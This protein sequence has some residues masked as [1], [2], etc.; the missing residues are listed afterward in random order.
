MPLEIR[1][2]VASDLNNLKQVIDSA[3]LF[4]SELLD[5]MIKPYF[6]GH[7]DCLWLTADVDEPSFVAYCAPE[8]MTDGTWNLYLV[9][10][11][12]DFQGKGIGRQVI[13]YVEER[14]KEREV[15]VLIIE[16]SGLPEYE[17]TREFYRKCN[18][19]EEARIRDFYEAG[20]DKIVFWK[21]LLE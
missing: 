12:A 9:A 10:V 3:E 19:T 8:K 13:H 14:L 7:A 17:Q 2:A 1:D 16:T 20:D 18:Y 5:N 11:H 6:A 21:S 15:R 4:P